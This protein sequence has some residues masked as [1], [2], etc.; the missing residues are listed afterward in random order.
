ML[1]KTAETDSRYAPVSNRYSR[2]EKTFKKLLQGDPDFIPRLS[3][4]VFGAQSAVYLGVRP[5]ERYSPENMSRALDNVEVG[6][7]VLFGLFAISKGMEVSTSLKPASFQNPES[8]W[9]SNIFYNGEP[10]ARL[11]AN[12]HLENE[13]IVM[14]ITT[15]QGNKGSASLV[16][17]R[18]NL[19]ENHSTFWPIEAISAML[20][21]LPKEIS[22]V[23]GISSLS[24]PEQGRLAFHKSTFCMYDRTFRKMGWAEKNSQDNS[25]IAYYEFA[26]P[27]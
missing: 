11:G 23:R 1:A 6:L 19:K 4:T 25:G 18:Q 16:A 27:G 26:P 21:K 10:V 7:D 12:L 14:S 2:L 15:I 20:Q 22:A 24:H 3:P 8:I 9:L 13:K 5:V 17:M